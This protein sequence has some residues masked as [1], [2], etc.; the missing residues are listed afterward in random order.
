MD[1]KLTQFWDE[2]YHREY[3]ERHN[4]VAYL[5]EHHKEYL[6]IAWIG[7]QQ[8]GRGFVVLDFASAVM[9]P[10]GN[11]IELPAQYLTTDELIAKESSRYP[12]IVE[13]APRIAN[14]YDPT[15]GMAFFKSFPNVPQLG[16]MA[17]VGVNTFPFPMSQVYEE[18][19]ASNRFGGR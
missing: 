9:D 19:T 10:A 16:Y 3:C 11:I 1:L 12:W 18:V 15:T 2:A 17:C 14:L 4:W 7:Y 5:Q 6:A 8:M 13:S